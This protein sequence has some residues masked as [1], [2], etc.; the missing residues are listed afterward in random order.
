MT[1]RM[2]PRFTHGE[3]ALIK[4][5]RSEQYPMEG[6][7]QF[8]IPHDRDEIV[9]AIFALMREDTITAALR[10]VN[11]VLALQT[12]GEPLVNGNRRAAVCR[13][14]SDRPMYKDDF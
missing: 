11:H 9:E 3:M 6:I 14:W 12:A 5:M 7:C 1:E 4:H 8:L 2:M 10:H 13:N